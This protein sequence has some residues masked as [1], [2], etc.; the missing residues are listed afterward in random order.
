MKIL[1]VSPASD[2]TTQ[3]RDAL[4]AEGH[5][6][7]WLDDRQDYSLPSFLR[8]W[9]LLWRVSRRIRPLR[10]RSIRALQARVLES[11][12]G[13]D[14]LFSNKGMNI[15]PPTLAALKQM[16]V[17]TAVWMPD[18]AANEPYRSW[19]RNAGQLWDRL[20]SFD[21]AIYDQTP[22][23]AH[24]RVHVLP[25]G[26]DPAAY[27]PEPISDADRAEYSCDIAFV[28][29]PYPDRVELLQTVVGR[30][31]KIWG[32]GGWKKTPL[33]K[34][35]RGPLNA[36]QSAKAYRLAKIA[37]NTNVRPIAKGVNV[38]TFEICAA[39]G[40]QLTD[41]PADLRQSFAIGKELDVFHDA[42]EFRD[43]VEYWLG[44]DDER[45]AVAG[46]GRERVVRDH[47][48]RQRMRRMIS[49]L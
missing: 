49:L 42:D 21:S 16:G 27:D 9:R 8:S 23:E 18:N 4:I 24:T 48:M 46:A 43:R 15:K 7:V 36:R 45:R 19:V 30:N 2:T 25:F 38:K 37:V 6:V 3:I 11:A 14:L 39:G 41:E 5:D 1:F 35:Y 44:H 22:T 47:T 10:L 13:K 32:W 12:K 26:V 17:K 20:F 33:A 28:G 31:L 29:A 40:F 34:H